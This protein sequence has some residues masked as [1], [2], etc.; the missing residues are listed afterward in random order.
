MPWPSA[1][2]SICA[3]VC[4]LR[5]AR[6]CR[7]F[8]SRPGV[9]RPSSVPATG[10]TRPLR[11][12]STN[13]AAAARQLNLIDLRRVEPTKL[14]DRFRAHEALRPDELRALAPTARTSSAWELP[15][16]CGPGG[17]GCGT[18]PTASACR[19]RRPLPGRRRRAVPLPAWRSW[20]SSALF[21]AAQRQRH[22]SAHRAAPDE[23][24]GK[25]RAVLHAPQAQ[26]R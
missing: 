1:A 11:R 19:S 10:S 9:C 13:S 16:P 17:A 21:S 14:Y 3:C 8:S 18:I 5:T 12:R 7:P 25:Q 22:C 2:A 20:P 4:R 6:P 15:P 23:P 24:T 26:S